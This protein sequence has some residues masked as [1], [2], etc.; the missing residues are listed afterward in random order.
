MIEIVFDRQEFFEQKER[1]KKMEKKVESSLN[2]DIHI[3]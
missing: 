2:E 3:A 1:A